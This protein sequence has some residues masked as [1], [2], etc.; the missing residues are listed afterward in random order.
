MGLVKPVRSFKIRIIPY[1]TNKPL[2]FWSL[3]T[4]KTIVTS[5][6]GTRVV[7]AQKLAEGLE[8]S[9]FHLMLF[10]LIPEQQ[11]LIFTRPKI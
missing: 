7:S 5:I 3:N 1:K 2:P 11:S 8:F 4:T 6:Y 9:R 10:P